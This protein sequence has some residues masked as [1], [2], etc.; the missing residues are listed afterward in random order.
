MVILGAVTHNFVEG[1]VYLA[2]GLKV[3]KH[4]GSETSEVEVEAITNCAPEL[5]SK[6]AKDRKL[7]LNGLQY[8]LCTGESLVAVQLKPQRRVD[9]MVKIVGH[10][11]KSNQYTVLF[12]DG[13]K[14]Y[15]HITNEA[16]QALNK[17]PRRKCYQLEV[18]DVVIA[19][20]ASCGYLPRSPA[21]GPG[22]VS[23]SHNITQY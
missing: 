3:T 16:L 11:A 8:A 23:Q 7:G 14:K 15:I 4:R 10:T 1:S 17:H 21:N 19:I 12:E 13:T 22:L 2:T 20:M 18:G 9:W 5:K 6:F